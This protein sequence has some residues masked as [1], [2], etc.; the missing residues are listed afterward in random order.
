M[1]LKWSAF[2]L[3]PN[4]TAP[5]AMS[6]VVRS[7]TTSPFSDTHTVWS[8]YTRISHRSEPPPVVMLNLLKQ[9]AGTA[10]WSFTSQSLRM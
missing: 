10:P 7:C 5:S 8:P 3:V 2:G 1:W 6:D 4:P 9:S